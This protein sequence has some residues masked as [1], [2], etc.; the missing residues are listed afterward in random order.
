MGEQKTAAVVSSGAWENREGPDDLYDI[1]IV[2][3]GPTG[4]FAAYYAGF[5]GLRM[6]IIDSLPDLGGQIT[7]LYPEKYIYDVAGFP[8]V[9]GKDL[10]K[11]LVAQ[12]EQYNP[13]ICLHEQ[14]QRI[15]PVG[16]K[17]IKVV[18]DAREH[19]TKV[20]VLSAGIGMFTPTK[21]KGFESYEGKGL[22]Y[23]VGSK[24]EFRNKTLLIL[25][26]GDSAVDW[27]LN[28]QD[29]AEKIILIHR[30]DKFRAHEDSVR[31]LMESPAEVKLFYEI[32]QVLGNGRVEGAVIFH[33]KTKEEETV[34]VDAILSCL[35]FASNLGPIKSW[36]LQLEGNGIVVNTKMETDTPG[37]Y[38]CGDVAVYPGKVKLIA[39][40]FGEAAIAINNAAIYINPHE[41]LFAGYSTTRAEQAEAAAAGTAATQE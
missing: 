25:G 22:Y 13:T 37:V 41:K 32:K 3:G 19:W 4:L 6:K 39:V 36:G 10:V 18:T 29:I 40:D 20:V 38:G 17:R 11:A 27:V 35:G 2:G 28:L 26:G 16:E 31:Q 12:A 5:R 21:L 33:N 30:R 34:A 23:F 1:T 8:K 7:A 14:V 24:E 15:E 9:L